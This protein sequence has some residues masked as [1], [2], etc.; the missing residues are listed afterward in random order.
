MSIGL[1]ESR[2]KSPFL[3][4]PRS[5]SPAHALRLPSLSL[6][7]RRSDQP[8][9]LSMYAPRSPGVC[10]MR[11]ASVRVHALTFVSCQPA[12]GAVGL[13]LEPQQDRREKPFRG[14]RMLPLNACHATRVQSRPAGELGLDWHEHARLQYTHSPHARMQY[15]HHPLRRAAAC[16]RAQLP[17][18]CAHLAIRQLCQSELH[19]LLDP[20]NRKI[21]VGLQRGSW[22]SAAC[23]D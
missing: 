3:A 11:Q 18:I 1:L 10:D 5:R 12:R 8:D 20:Q 9:G 7:G 15:T 22:A 21:A 17:Y 19:A 6:T 4:L 13:R 16:T 14:F 23:R 2:T